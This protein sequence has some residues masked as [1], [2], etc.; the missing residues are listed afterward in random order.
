M[1]LAPA[2]AFGVPLGVFY[3][4]TLSLMTRALFIV[5]VVGTI[6]LSVAMGANAG[7]GHWAITFPW[8]VL[9]GH[10]SGVQ[11]ISARGWMVTGII[12]ACS[13]PLLGALFTATMV[14]RR[15]SPAYLGYMEIVKAHL[16]NS[17]PSAED[18]AAMRPPPALAARS[19]VRIGAEG[20]AVYL[21]QGYYA[22]Y[23]SLQHPFVPCYGAGNSM[24]L[25]RQVAR[26]TGH[27]E[28]LECAYPARLDKTGAF[29]TRYWTTIYPWIA[30]DVSF[31]GTVLVVLA[32]GWLS[33]RVWL[34][35]LGGRN[36]AA[37]AL[38]GQILLMLYYVPA[39][40]KIMQTGEGLS[41]F[42]TI[43]GVWLV[44]RRRTEDGA[45]DTISGA[46]PQPT[47]RIDANSP[48]Y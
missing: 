3:W 42:A 2:L 20:L 16:G 33:G 46:N 7:A 21:T 39:H 8:L 12:L 45:G 29:A 22:V 10:V 13:G 28:I 18:H 15:G 1:L 4:R 36:P 6:A 26:V 9:A 11:R 47:N 19:A 41:A 31:P 23:L 43:L 48:G 37:V 30:S 32:I 5:S 44:S 24:F 38:F 35:V 27:D 40:N 34:D 17:P 25:Q 14:H